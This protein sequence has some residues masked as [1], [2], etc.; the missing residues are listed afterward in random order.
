MVYLPPTSAFNPAGAASC[1]ILTEFTVRLR[2]KRKRERCWDRGNKTTI[3][4]EVVLNADIDICKDTQMARS[5][6]L[7]LSYYF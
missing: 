1:A 4:G 6:T 7:I 2:K 5:Y 3:N